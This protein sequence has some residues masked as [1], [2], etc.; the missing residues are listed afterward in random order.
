MVSLADFPEHRREALLWRY[1]LELDYDGVEDLV[2]AGVNRPC[3]WQWWWGDLSAMAA[4]LGDDSHFHLRLGQKVLCALRPG[5]DDPDGAVLHEHPDHDRGRQHRRW[6]V[7]LGRRAV[8][9]ESVPYGQR[10]P[11]DPGVWP[12]FHDPATAKG[13]LRIRLAAE[14]GRHCHACRQGPT[15]AVDHD[16]FTGLIRGML[17]RNCNSQVD[18]CPH[19]T[20]CPFADYLNNPPAARLQLTFTDKKANRPS[21]GDK[22]RIDRLGFNPF[23]R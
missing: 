6:T 1:A 22:L 14:L 21:P 4:V 11:G 2:V 20:G 16:H 5:R 9:A 12:T 8:P 15:F 13:R 23:A 19:L 17:C 18:H 10:C 7:R 3:H